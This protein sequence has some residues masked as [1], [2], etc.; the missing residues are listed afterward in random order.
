MVY[1]HQSR[2]ISYTYK[3]IATY[4]TTATDALDYAFRLKKDFLG[5]KL[6]I[7]KEIHNFAKFFQHA[8][9]LWE[10]LQNINWH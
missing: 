9:A 8:I 5:G 2:G 1:P 3:I 7:W 6:I 10:S 4:D